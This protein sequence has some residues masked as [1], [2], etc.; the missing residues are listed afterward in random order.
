M[1]DSRGSYTPLFAATGV[2]KRRR[3]IFIGVAATLALALLILIVTP[4][5]RPYVDP[6]KLVESFGS[7][8]NST[9]GADNTDSSES[10]RVKVWF[11]EDIPHYPLPKFDV[12]KLKMYAAHNY[13]GAGHPAYA[14]LYATRDATMYDP[15]FLAAQQVVYRLLWQDGRKSDKYPVVVFV[16][17]FVPQTHRDYFRAAG[18]IVREIGLHDIGDA[19]MKT[20]RYRD[21]YSKLNMWRHTDFSLLFYTDADALVWDNPDTIFDDPVPQQ[22]KPDLLTPEDA[23]NAPGICNYTFAAWI[24]PSINELNAGVM[25]FKP[26]YHMYEHLMRGLLTLDHPED[27]HEQNYLNGS[28][29]VAG[30]FPRRELDDQWN[31]IR[32]KEKHFYI[33]HGKPWVAVAGNWI[34]Q[35]WN[36]TWAGMRELY[37]SPEFVKKREEDQRKAMALLTGS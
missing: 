28:F 33:L 15:L 9:D 17:N 3:L 2:E 6:T 22:C 25:L 36:D 10:T 31:S 4:A 11:E 29:S 16:P 1:P 24:E 19:D 27:G 30:P 35:D 34:N 21:Q 18:A 13:K 7:K 5:T 37:E 14:T 32:S 20:S 23:R 12:D 26:S 8:A